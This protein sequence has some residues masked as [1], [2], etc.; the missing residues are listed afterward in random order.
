MEM[1]RKENV[2]RSQDP[3]APNSTATPDVDAAT[4]LTGVTIDSTLTTIFGDG[5]EP[6]TLTTETF[7]ARHVGEVRIGHTTMTVV[8]VKE[9]LTVAA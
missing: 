9:L 3:V 8:L 2:P 7:A 5:I 1:D 4:D 6:T